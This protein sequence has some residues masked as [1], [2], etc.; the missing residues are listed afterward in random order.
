[1]KLRRREFVGMMGASLAS[2][3]VPLVGSGNSAP[4]SEWAIEKNGWQMTVTPYGDIV[5]VR[6]GTI[7]LVNRKVSDNFPRIIGSVAEVV[8][9]Q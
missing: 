8:Q 4:E 7:E 9:L 2:M 5:S 3:S 1:M 6:K